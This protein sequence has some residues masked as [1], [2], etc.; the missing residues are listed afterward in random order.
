VAQRF[1]EGIGVGEQFSTSVIDL[2]TAVDLISR[3]MIGSEIVRYP[4]KDSLRHFRAPIICL[5]RAVSK[6]KA[7]A[8][9]ADS[10]LPFQI[11]FE[12]LTAQS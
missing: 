1:A 11:A 7:H 3:A 10:F 2:F 8:G 4:K 12:Q 6:R 5:N 9:E